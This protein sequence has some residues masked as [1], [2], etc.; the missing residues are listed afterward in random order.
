MA[1]TVKLLGVPV[2]LYFEAHRHMLE[3]V[4]EFAL[5]S[6]G[7]KSGNT[8]PVP[9]RLLALVDQLGKQYAPGAD[10][11]RSQVEEAADAGRSTA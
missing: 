5:I 7:D 1:R 2:D 4:R 9:A 11:V 8:D 10:A 6:F 3:I